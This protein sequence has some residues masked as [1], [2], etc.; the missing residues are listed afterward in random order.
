M[1]EIEDNIDRSRQW[2]RR[3]DLF[4]IENHQ[5]WCVLM[6]LWETSVWIFDSV[7]IYKMM[8]GLNPGQHND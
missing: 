5:E 3:F 2:Q 7:L 1:T 8:K 4:G 6:G